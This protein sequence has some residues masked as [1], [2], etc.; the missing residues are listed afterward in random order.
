[1]RE[2]GE[3]SRK[4]EIRISGGKKEGSNEEVK[5]K[6]GENKNRGEMKIQRKEW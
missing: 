6:M 3:G 4:K 1:M 2:R 5:K